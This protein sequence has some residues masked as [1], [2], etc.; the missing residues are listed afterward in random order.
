M[1]TRTDRM[2]RRDLRK[3][4]TWK[5]RTE[6]DIKK[7]R[8]DVNLSTRDLKGELKNY[9]KTIESRKND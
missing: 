9:M 2:K 7:L 8:Q 3:K 6:G 1:S 5:R 4:P